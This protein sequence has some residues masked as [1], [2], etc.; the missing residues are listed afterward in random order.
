MSKTFLSRAI[1]FQLAVFSFLSAFSQNKKADE[2]ERYIRPLADAH[3]FSGVVVASYKGKVIY[4]KAFGSAVAEFNL[5]NQTQTRFCIASVTK[6]MTEVIALK[7]A[8]EGKLQLQDKISKWVPDFPGGDKIT[9]EMLMN[10]TSGIPHR[11][12]TEEQ[13][14][15][16]YSSADMLEKAKHVTLEFEPGTQESYSSLGYSVLARILELASGKSYAELLMKYVFQPAGMSNSL[17]FKS[18]SVIPLEAHEYLLE[19]TKM[20]P[21]PLKDYSFIVGAGSVCSTGSDVMR[22]AEA[23]VNDKYGEE[24]RKTLTDSTGRFR[25]NGSTYAFRC[26]VSMDKKKGYGFVIIS[27][28]SSGAN[29]LLVRDL[30]KILQDQPVSPPP[31]PHFQFEQLSRDKMNEY[32]GAY[33]FPRFTNHITLVRDQIFS[34]DS[35]IYYIGNDQFFR[36]SDYARLTF[37]RDTGG[38]IQGLKWES[39]STT[40]NGVRQ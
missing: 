6:P 16:P 32:L 23:L 20:V 8:G 4:E 33:E 5:P 38:K 1:I 22:F 7:L 35:R 21:A 24:V 29:D 12:T 25:D 27:N 13:E 18:D 34:G 30:P 11:A 15:Q 17:D 36:I 26:F 19:S 3:Q 37:S 10:H 9:I 2:I 31:V 39:L 40:F 28:L 14:A